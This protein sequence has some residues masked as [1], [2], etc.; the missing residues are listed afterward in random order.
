MGLHNG[1]VDADVATGGKPVREKFMTQDVRGHHHLCFV[2]GLQ[3]A[4]K[5][6]GMVGV[7]M[8]EDKEIYIF[9]RHPKDTGIVEELSGCPHIYQPA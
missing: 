9:Y 3:E 8:G 7:S 6:F 1:M 2:V 4:G 5:S